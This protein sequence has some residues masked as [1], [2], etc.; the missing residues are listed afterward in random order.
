MSWGCTRSRRCSDAACITMSSPSLVPAATRL[1]SAET[2]RAVTGELPALAHCSTR[3][4]A[5]L[6]RTTQPG[7]PVWLMAA[8]RLGAPPPLTPLMRT[9]RQ[10]AFFFFCFSVAN[11]LCIV[12]G[13]CA[14]AVGGSV[15]EPPPPSG[16]M[17]HW[18]SGA[19]VQS[20]SPSAL[21]QQLLTSLV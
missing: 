4:G 13:G 6:A 10:W 15:R 20:V 11:I 9:Q 3:A 19:T 21:K 12:N 2:S 1:P 7:P 16:Q 8:K 18:P 5:R 17:R 14:R